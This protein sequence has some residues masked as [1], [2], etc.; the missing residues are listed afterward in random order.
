MLQNKLLVELFSFESFSI[1]IHF[2]LCFAQLNVPLKSRRRG[3]LVRDNSNRADPEL[4]LFPGHKMLPVSRNEPCT[5]SWLRA[6]LLPLGTNIKCVAL[7]K[8]A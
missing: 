4:S 2:I 5:V 3:K 7:V 8:N 6:A 1:I